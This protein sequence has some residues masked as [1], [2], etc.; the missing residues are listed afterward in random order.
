MAFGY[1][2]NATFSTS[3]SYRTIAVSMVVLGAGL[4]LIMAPAPGSIKS[5]LPMHEAGV[6]SGVNDTTR[7]LGGI[8]GVALIGSVFASAYSAKLTSA[9]RGLC[10]GTRLVRGSR[11]DRSGV[12][13]RPR[14]AGKCTTA[15]PKRGLRRI[16][17]RVLPRAAVSAVV[18]ALCAIIALLFLPDPT[19]GR[20][21]ASAPTRCIGKC[22]H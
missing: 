13:G 15:H 5:S 14:C 22:A 7:L 11:L 8:I 10:P 20:G 4:G 3:T 19:K 18:A 17:R 21:P 9:L 6:G 1:A 12:R 16:H 2:L